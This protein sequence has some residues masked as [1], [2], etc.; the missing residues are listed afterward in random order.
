MR[1]QRKL[2]RNQMRKAVGNKGLKFQWSRFQHD[3]IEKI[4]KNI[5]KE[6]NVNKRKKDFA[7]VDKLNVYLDKLKENQKFL[8]RRSQARGY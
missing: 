4:I 7:A 5:T 3:R 6:L 8:Y 1:S 2:V